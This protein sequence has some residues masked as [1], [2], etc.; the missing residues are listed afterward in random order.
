M[1]FDN[2]K[3]SFYVY[4]ILGDLPE[5]HLE[6]FAEKAVCPLENVDKDIST[7][8]AGRHLLERRIDS[9]TAYNGEFLTLHFRSAQRK[10]PASLLS[11]ECM[12][13]ELALMEAEKISSVS[14]KRKKEIKE[15]V[16]KELI[17]YMPPQLTGVPFVVDATHKILYIGSASV[18]NGDNLVELFIRTCDVEVVPKSPNTVAMKTVETNSLNIKSLSFTHRVTDTEETYLGR[19]FLTWLW[20]RSEAVSNKFVV[21]DLGEFSFG[22]DGP[23]TLVAEEGNVQEAVLRKGLP[24]VSAEAFT[25]I[26]NGKKL[27]SAKVSL[28]LGDD[29]WSFTLD[30]DTFTFKSMNLPD[31][32]AMDRVARFE[33]RIESLHTFQQAFFWLYSDFI[34]MLSGKDRDE[35][36]K[37][38]VSWTADSYLKSVEK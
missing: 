26:M 13:R 33:E 23:L 9:E 21:P 14:K 16:E 24:T 3:I 27:R 1:A 2:G 34:K 29:I 6:L 7:G 12:Q 19:D 32:Q 5:N 4:E 36:E 25:G 10:I 17:K 20:Y 11:A 22:I 15:E 28:T 37:D 8:W 31:G 30:A 35:H 18:K 38:I